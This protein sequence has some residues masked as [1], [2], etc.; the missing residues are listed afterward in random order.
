MTLLLLLFVFAH[1]IDAKESKSTK[2]S[3][4]PINFILKGIDEKSYASEDYRGKYV[5]IDLWAVWCITCRDVFPVLNHFRKQYSEDKLAIMGISIDQKP[6][7]YVR[8]FAKKMGIQY[9]VLVDPKQ[10]MPPL[11][12]LEAVPSLY[13]LD[14]AGVIVWANKGYS[15]KGEKTLT[16]VLKAAMENSPALVDSENH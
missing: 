16:H 13:L 9:T 10:T 4:E 6:L 8:D 7:A 14:T 12:N 11:F 1:S 3:D 2:L 15:L 5:L